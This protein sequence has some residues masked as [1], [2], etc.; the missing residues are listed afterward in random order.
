MKRR[1][2]STHE[3]RTFYDRMG[4]GLDH[5]RFYERA[6]IAALIEHGGF[7]KARSV[8]ELGCGTGAFAEELL[9]KILPRDASYTGVDISPMMVKISRARLARFAGRA[10][11]IKSAGA[12]RFDL[13]ENSFDR[14]I[15]SYVLDILSPE[16]IKKALVEAH[17]LLRKGGKVC[18]LS[19]TRGNSIPSK[20]LS[21]FWD[22]LHRVNPRIV[23]GCRPI[24]LLDF[25]EEN[26]WAL[27]FRGV[28]VSFGV[29]SEVVVASAVK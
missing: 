16:E 24:E 13:P 19:L 4:R 14:F 29:P 23:G 1:F 26:K 5:H 10:R 3:V 11:I 28:A 8:F 17:R 12:L 9:E 18:L 21:G 25:V 6:A 27:E 22:T 7:T 15:A 2:L 20:A